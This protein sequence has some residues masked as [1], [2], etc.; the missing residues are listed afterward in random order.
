MSR[1]D[2]DFSL[3]PE[4]EQEWIIQNTWCDTCGQADLGMNFTQEYEEYGRIF[5]EGQCLK[6]GQVVQSEVKDE[7]AG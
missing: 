3:R 2:R 6:C 1:K 4:E 7:E 5:V